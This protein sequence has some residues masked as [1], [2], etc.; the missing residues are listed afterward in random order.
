MPVGW[1]AK[2]QG[3]DLQEGKGQ[4]QEGIKTGARWTGRRIGKVTEEPKKKGRT[5]STPKMP[6]AEATANQWLF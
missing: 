4:T 5:D 1:P 2:L 6:E 3:H